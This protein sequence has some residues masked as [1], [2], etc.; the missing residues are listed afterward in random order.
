VPVFPKGSDFA[1]TKLENCDLYDAYPLLFLLVVKTCLPF[2]NSRV[3][4]RVDVEQLEFY[5][6][7][8]AD[9]FALPIFS[10]LPVPNER[11]LKC[12]FTVDC[13]VRKN[14]E[15]LFR[16]LGGPCF[17]IYPEDVSDRF[18]AKHD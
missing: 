6:R 1:A 14:R 18:R 15:N 3:S 16:V 11:L 7:L 5:V 13:I 9:Y 8:L 17:S 4:D 12:P 10:D 2:S